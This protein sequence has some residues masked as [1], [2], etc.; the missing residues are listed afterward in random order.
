MF[1]Q[2]HILIS[3]KEE[4]TF[5]LEFF[6]ADPFCVTNSISKGT[7]ILYSAKFSGTFLIA[8]FITCIAWK[9]DN[10]VSS[11]GLRND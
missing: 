10:L 9:G 11:T 1:P 8:N 4:I 7:A 5:A 2:G 6:C 3:R